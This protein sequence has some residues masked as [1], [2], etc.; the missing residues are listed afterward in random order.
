MVCSLLRNMSPS[1]NNLPDFRA[2]QLEFAAHIR[3]PEEN[4]R[5]TDV[6]ARRMKIYLEL[7]YNNIEGFLA[8]GFPISKKIL[9]EDAWHALVRTFVHRH[10]S[11]SPYFLEISQEFLTFL[12]T[13]APG[14]DSLPGFLLELAHY[15]WVELALG[16]S[17]LSIPE[18]GFNANGDL[19]EGPLLLSPLIWCLAYR[20][21]VH[22]IG[23]EHLPEQPPADPTQ[24]I[25]YR[26]RDDSVAFLE[27]NAVTLKL[28]Q[29][30]ESGETAASA[31]EQI[32]EELPML[33]S[34]VIYE[35]G[36]ATLSRL[37]DAQIILGVVAGE[38]AS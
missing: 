26:R 18:T 29:L 17:E 27:V 36:I 7:F 21:P 3:N 23:P 9:G 2:T 8:S 31:F 28:V 4:P 33:D 20:W 13:H 16:V 10:P 38:S 15:E 6:E 24:L 22:Q 37:R 34:K 5:P 12:S 32:G 30:L 19:L 25:V 14:D 11:E 35:Q 1:G